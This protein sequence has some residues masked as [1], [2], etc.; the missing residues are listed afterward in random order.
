[1]SRDWPIQ[2]F[3]ELEK[4][5]AD[6]ATTHTLGHRDRSNVGRAGDAVADKY[7]KSARL[8]VKARHVDLAFRSPAQSPV[9]MPARVPSPR[10]HEISGGN[11]ACLTSFALQVCRFT[12]SRARV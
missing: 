1:M 2:V 9:Q 12:G 5:G 7:D 11:R 4:P 6:A 3:R 10:I 8:S